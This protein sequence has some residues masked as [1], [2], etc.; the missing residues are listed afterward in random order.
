MDNYSDEVINLI[1]YFSSYFF[2]S[3]SSARELARLLKY[4]GEEPIQRRR[5]SEESRWARIMRR[6]WRIGGLIKNREV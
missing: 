2:A 6:Y 1:N 5:L 3:G 4:V